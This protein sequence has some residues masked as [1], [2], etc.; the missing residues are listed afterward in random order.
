MNS[1][2]S[3]KKDPPESHYAVVVVVYKLI[4]HDLMDEIEG[5]YRR[6]TIIFLGDTQKG[7]YCN[8]GSESKQNY[9]E[10]INL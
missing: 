7:I 2:Q 9:S 3:K 6:I 8:E 1:C 10:G 4:S 5:N